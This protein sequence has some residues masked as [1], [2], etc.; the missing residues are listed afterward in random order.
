MIFSAQVCERDGV[1]WADVESG[2]LW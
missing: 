1:L 2:W